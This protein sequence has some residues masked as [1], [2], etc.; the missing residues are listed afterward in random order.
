[1]G[2]GEDNANAYNGQHTGQIGVLVT[3]I[4]YDFLTPFSDERGGAVDPF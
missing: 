1:M 2:A 4:S 3:H